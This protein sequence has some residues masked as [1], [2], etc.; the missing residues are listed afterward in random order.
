LPVRRIVVIYFGPSF[1]AASRKAFNLCIFSI[2]AACRAAFCTIAS[3]FAFFFLLNVVEYV[4]D[5]WLHYSF[6]PLTT[7]SNGATLASASLRAAAI[8]SR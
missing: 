2:T 4:S 5:T 8:A 7:A 3:L 1:S 6:V